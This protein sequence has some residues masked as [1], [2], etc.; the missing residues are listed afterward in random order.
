[1]LIYQKN[2]I[3]SLHLSS[4]DEECRN[5]IKALPTHM[6]KWSYNKMS[7]E[8]SLTT[9]KTYIKDKY[10][11]VFSIPESEGKKIDEEFL[12]QFEDIYEV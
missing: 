10:Q 2:L 1:M 12:S 5:F 6:R 4:Y 9:F 3:V 8:I 11:E 7:W